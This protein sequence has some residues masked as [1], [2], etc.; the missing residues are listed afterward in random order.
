MGGVLALL[1][2]CCSTPSASRRD[3][4]PAQ[5]ASALPSMGPVLLGLWQH[6]CLPH[7]WS[8]VLVPT[9]AVAW[10]PP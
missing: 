9:A 8:P 2:S 7:L 6:E 5:V 1:S 3:Y 4:S 10:G